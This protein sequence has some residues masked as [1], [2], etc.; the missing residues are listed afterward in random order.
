MPGCT[1]ADVRAF[2][3]FHAAH[4]GRRLLIHCTAGLSRSPAL[5]ILAYMLDGASARD[6]CLGVCRAVPEASP[7]HRVL[8]QAEQALSLGAGAIL[9]RANRTFLYRHGAHGAAGVRTGL[10]TIGEIPGS[11][12]MTTPS[13]VLPSQ[14]NPGGHL[15]AQAPT[16][17]KNPRGTHPEVSHD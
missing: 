16:A 11:K 3:R 6:A 9:D 12:A 14:A 8:Y 5:A 1:I 15:G 17:H 10:R 2:V 4:R 7:N 13:R